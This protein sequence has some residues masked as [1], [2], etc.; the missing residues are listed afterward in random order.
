MFAVWGLLVLTA[1]S[2]WFCSCWHLSLEKHVLRLRGVF[3]CVSSL[4]FIYLI[5]PL[6][7]CSLILY[8]FPPSLLLR[9][10]LREGWMAFNICLSVRDIRNPS[11]SF[12]GLFSVLTRL[13]SGDFWAEFVLFFPPLHHRCIL[14][15]SGCLWEIMGA[16]FGALYLMLCVLYLLYYVT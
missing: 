12:I 3:F 4:S 15:G 9:A 14:A 7:S 13:L 6:S 1:V 5:N 8:L 16:A 10:L 2:L 11:W